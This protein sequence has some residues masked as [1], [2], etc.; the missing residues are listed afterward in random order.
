VGKSD[1]L[2]HRQSDFLADFVANCRHLSVLW[3]VG[4]VGTLVVSLV[5]ESWSESK[6]NQ[7]KLKTLK[8]KLKTKIRRT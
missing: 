8:Y 3:S 5:S 6:G 2:F 4:T 7:V 1:S